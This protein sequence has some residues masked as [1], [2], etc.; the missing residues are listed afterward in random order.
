MKIQIFTQP[1]KFNYGGILQAYALQQV[2]LRL[3]HD[4]VTIDRQ[5]PY[6]HEGNSTKDKWQRVCSFGKCLVRRLILRQRYV[7]LSNPFSRAYHIYDYAAL[8][9]PFVKRHMRTS[10]TMLRNDQLLRYVARHQAD[11][12]I[13][14][15][16]QVWREEYSPCIEHYFL[17]FLPAD[18]KAR[19]IA[20]AASLGINEHYISEAKMPQCRELLKRFDAISVREHSAIDVLRRDFGCDAVKVLDP[21]LLL[22]ADDYLLLIDKADRRSTAGLTTYILDTTDEKERIVADT[23]AATGITQRTLR[24]LEAGDNREQHMMLW[25]VSQW[26]A[27]IADA[28]FVVTDSFHGCVFSIIF[29]KPFVAIAN[30]VRGLDRFTSLLTPLGLEY[31]LV[32]DYDDFAARRASLLAPIDY[33]EVHRRITEARRQSMKFLIDALAQEKA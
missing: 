31:R 14:G 10:P 13:V 6:E 22:C 20:Y 9:A 17:S 5:L 8:I 18:S 12:Y 26:L 2:L 28:E 25:P 1:L 27:S 33:A 32:S 16:D 7:L 11:A 30:A 23:M 24:S 3:G 29:G 15:S 21:T 19:R 4:V